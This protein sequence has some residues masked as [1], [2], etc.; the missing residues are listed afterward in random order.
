MFKKILVAN[1]GEIARR[2]I[3]A[4]H[5]LNIAAVAVYSE[6][7]VD[8]GYLKEA[9]EI[10]CIGPG[11][12]SESYLSQSAL[13][14]VA[15]QTECEALHPGYGFLAE[16]A[17][18]A[19]RCEQQKLTFIGPKPEH[20]RLMGDKAQARTT[21]Q[22]VGLPV[23]PGSLSI[24]NDVT[25]ASKMAS[26]IGYPVLLKATAG[27]GG[28]GMR[29]VSGP[30]EML[31]K[32]NEASLESEK[33]FGNAGLYMEKFISPARHIEFQVLADNYGK[34]IYFPERECSIQRNHQKLLEESPAFGIKALYRK[35]MGE[36][37]AE[38]LGIIGY[39]GAGTIEF[40]LDNHDKLYFMEMNT[41]IQVEH[42]VTEMVTGVDLVK[43]Q[44]AIAA[45]AH[46][47]LEQNKIILSGHAIECRLNAE[48]P[49]NNFLPDPGQISKCQF[50]AKDLEAQVRVDTHIET[51]YVIPPYYDSML[52]KVIVHAK[53]RKSAVKQM[54][55]VLD[56]TI[57]DGVKTT[58]PLQKQILANKEFKQGAYNCDFLNE[59]LWQK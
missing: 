55:K 15:E 28:K 23:M 46:L 47:T 14:K 58:L 38:A 48:D 21:M 7:D 11:P 30:S 54:Q 43:W 52:A 1:R 36:K 16:N 26:E 22:K 51:G 31:E 29:L 37:I 6:A 19:T 13:L 10:V 5:D 50:A 56:E 27:G 12:A 45:G 35:V 17:L 18:F 44:I 20:I 49:D 40:L 32:F 39:Q 34:V 8:A 42:P 57:V 53:D 59:V 2:I 3:K 24:L 9:D 33:A 41:R 4:C 25:S